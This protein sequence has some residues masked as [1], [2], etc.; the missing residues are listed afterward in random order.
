MFL[1]LTKYQLHNLIKVKSIK[2]YVFA[3]IIMCDIN[4]FSYLIIIHCLLINIIYHNVPIFDW[5]LVVTR[6]WIH[7]CRWWKSA[8]LAKWQFKCLVARLEVS[9]PTIF[10]RRILTSETTLLSWGTSNNWKLV[11]VIVYRAQLG[12]P[13]RK[14][15]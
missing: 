1:R 10:W 6:H 3:S 5:F 7:R 13:R 14:I 9:K 2:N 4:I 15:P 11:I 12:W 8:N